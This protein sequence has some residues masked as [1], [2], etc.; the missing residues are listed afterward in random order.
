MSDVVGYGCAL[1]ALFVIVVAVVGGLL[2][3]FLG[4]SSL[5]RWRRRR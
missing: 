5:G 3:E 2:M 4:Y 1:L